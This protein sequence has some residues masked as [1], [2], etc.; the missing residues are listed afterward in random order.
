ML[1]PCVLEVLFAFVPH[2]AANSP[3]QQTRGFSS[4]ILTVFH[5]IAVR[6]HHLEFAPPVRCVVITQAVST[7]A[8]LSS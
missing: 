3:Q 7:K 6:T 4:A 5:C 2:L 8:L 1:F